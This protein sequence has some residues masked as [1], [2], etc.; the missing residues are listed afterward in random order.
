M[1][2]GGS[3]AGFSRIAQQALYYL[4]V[5]SQQ[6][7][8]VSLDTAFNQISAA[9]AGEHEPPHIVLP[10]GARAGEREPAHVALST[11]QKI[12]KERRP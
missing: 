5:P 4:Q 3:R 6:A 1:G 7:Q 12:E 11:G 9:P 8:T 2:G 10:L